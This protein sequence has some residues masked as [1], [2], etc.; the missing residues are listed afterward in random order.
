MKKVV[1]GDCGFTYSYEESK[2]EKKDTPMDYTRN[3]DPNE[4][5]ELFPHQG[6]EEQEDRRLGQFPEVE[7]SHCLITKPF[8]VLLFQLS[9]TPDHLKSKKGLERVEYIGFWEMGARKRSVL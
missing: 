9:N 7:I 4:G 5:E 8:K 2:G 3:S 1:W 6:K